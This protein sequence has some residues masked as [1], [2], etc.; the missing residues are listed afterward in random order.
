M[1]SYKEISSNEEEQKRREMVEKQFE[2]RFN[3]IQNK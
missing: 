3:V 1:V 2:A